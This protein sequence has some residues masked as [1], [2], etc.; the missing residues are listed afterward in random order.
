MIKKIK[1][2]LSICIA[3]LVMASCS[4]TA[5]LA[6]TSNTLG[7]KVGEANATIVL[8]L[9]FGGDSERSLDPCGSS[10]PSAKSVRIE[11]QH[12]S[13]T[14]ESKQDSRLFASPERQRLRYLGRF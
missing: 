10:D 12:A 11:R 14:D 9:V 3:L 7:K 2:V 6:A 8:G 4:M 13:H 1:F 5:P